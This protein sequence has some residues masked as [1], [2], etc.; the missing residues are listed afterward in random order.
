MA[1]AADVN[2]VKLAEASDPSRAVARARVRAAD[3]RRRCAPRRVVLH[4][5]DVCRPAEVRGHL[6]CLRAWSPS[7]AVDAFLAQID[8]VVAHDAGTALR[9]IEAPDTD[10]AGAGPPLL[11]AVR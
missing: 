11:D 7:P 10:H 6:G 8:A 9:E 4:A 5:R 3:C 1:T 2:L